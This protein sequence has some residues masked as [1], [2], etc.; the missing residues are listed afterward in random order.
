MEWLARRLEEGPG[1]AGSLFVCG[2]CHSVP[3]C[4]VA[5]RPPSV[6]PSVRRPEWACELGEHFVALLSMPPWRRQGVVWSLVHFSVGVQAQGVPC[7]WRPDVLLRVGGA[8]VN[9][10][11]HRTVS[12]SPSLV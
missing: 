1:A 6:F 11:L 12:C 4:L 3:D 10:G 9:G 7:S 5:L 8:S 2:L